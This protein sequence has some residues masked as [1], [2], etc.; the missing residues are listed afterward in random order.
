MNFQAFVLEDLYIIQLYI[1]H[2]KFV[3]DLVRKAL[4]N[5]FNLIL[6]VITLLLPNQLNMSI[7]PFREFAEK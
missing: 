5:Y 2:L 3:L 4:Q 7:S 6:K 1:V